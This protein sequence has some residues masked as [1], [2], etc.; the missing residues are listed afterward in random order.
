MADQPKH[1]SDAE[2][3]EM[4]H[5]VTQQRGTEPPFSGTLLFNVEEGV[6]HC[7]VC[8]A[9]LFISDTKFDAGCGWPSFWRPCSDDA[10][11]Y[12]PDHSLTMPRTEI[13]CARCDAHLGHVFP[14]GPAPT[15][16]RYCVNSVSLSFIGATGEK[17][18]G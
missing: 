3:T 16:K 15:G 1:L 6:Y 17:T 7:L 4:Q 9:P 14:D 12:L 13:R 11:R 5:Y 18:T 2:L 8:D 10:I